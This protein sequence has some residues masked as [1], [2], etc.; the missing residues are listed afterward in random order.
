M[1]SPKGDLTLLGQNVQA[2]SS[3][4]GWA[5]VLTGKNALAAEGSPPRVVMFPSGA[6]N[7]AADDHHAAVAS[8]WMMVTA[9]FWA[10]GPGTDEAF[11]LRQR[12]MQALRAQADAGG[13]Y[14]KF[15]DSENERWNIQPDT[16][17][18]GQEFEIDIVI[19]ID[20]SMAAAYLGHNT[21]G[22]TSMN[23]VATLASAMGTGDN[24]ATVDATINDPTSG[25]LHVDNEQMS[26]TGRTGTT[27][28]GL[29]RGINGT[30]AATHVI[31]AAVYI[32]PT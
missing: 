3:M 28:T 29:V 13:Y 15:P 26:F 16:N 23:R 27:F 8:S 12:W 32:S 19:R 5:K 1:A 4:L 20:A 17:E 25:V 7:E 9:H 22:A 14:W 11:D 24:T 30:T 10:R 21:V 2:A 18:Q 6:K 31:G